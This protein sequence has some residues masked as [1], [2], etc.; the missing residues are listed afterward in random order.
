MELIALCRK[1]GLAI[2][3][4][5]FLTADTLGSAARVAD[6]DLPIVFEFERLHSPPEIHDRL[7]VAT[8]RILGAALITADAEIRSSG[9][10][11]TIW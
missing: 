3:L 8:A 5:E 1:R 9:Q 6:L 4:A 10:V 7:I 11:E 2:P